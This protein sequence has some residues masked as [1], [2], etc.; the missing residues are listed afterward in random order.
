MYELLAYS[1]IHNKR[2]GVKING[3]GFK[4]FEKLLNGWV[5]ISGGWDKI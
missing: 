4:D 5:K 2:G 3:G 1:Q